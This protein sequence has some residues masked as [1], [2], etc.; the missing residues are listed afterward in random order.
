MR[1]LKNENTDVRRRRDRPPT[2]IAMWSG[3]RNIS[4]ALM[5]SWGNRP[6]TAV[7]DEPLYCALPQGHRHRPPGPRRGHRATTN[8]T[9][10]RSRR[11]SPAPVPGG[12][13]ILYQKHMAHHLLPKIG[14]DWLDALTHAF[15]I[16][17]PR[18]ML[19]SL[20]ENLPGSR[21]SPTPACRSR[22]EIFDRIAS[23]HGNGAAG[24]ATR[25]TCSGTRAACSKRS[26]RRSAC[27]SR[28]R[29]SPGSR[30]GARP[31]AS[32]RSTGTRAVEA[33]TGFEP[34]RRT[35]GRTVAVRSADLAE[36]VPSLVRKAAR[37]A[38]PGLRQ[39]DA[40]A[41]RRAQPRP[42]RQHQRRARA[43]RPGGRQPVRLA[44]C[45]AAMPS[46]RGCGSTTAGSSSSTE[47]L[48]RL[49][50]SAL[51][52]AFD[53]IPTHEAIIEEIRRTLAANR[54]RDGV[55]IRLTLTR[56]VKITSGMDPR[57]NRSGP[58]LIVLAEHKPPVYR[59][60]GL[61]LITS[62]QPAFAARLPRPED[63]PRQPAPLDPGQDPG[64]RRGRRRRA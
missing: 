43:S 18:E 19:A 57:L 38:P 56:G 59:Q 64:Q 12:R 25:A 61:T 32:G 51:A 41:L 46:G 9:G 28:R 21:R 22:C 47:H 14:R 37:F 11:R 34:W 24:G 49:R 52:L 6:D 3:P 36:R 5:R 27:R 33:S 10:A 2:R 7:C 48:D 44:P 30:A 40:A 1:S 29:C 42:D 58:T 55:H 15:L 17:E 54:M 13:A 20:V 26:A 62:S 50:H 8:P 53:E 60:D 45:R 16:R 39:G 63:P 31:T 23:R 4:T 35:P